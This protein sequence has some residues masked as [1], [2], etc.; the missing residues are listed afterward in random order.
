MEKE[1]CTIPTL[2]QITGDMAGAATISP[3]NPAQD[4]Y[5]IKLDDESSNLCTLVPYLKRLH[6][7]A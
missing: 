3:L 1:Y 6:F 4:F 5:Q 2:E 7:M